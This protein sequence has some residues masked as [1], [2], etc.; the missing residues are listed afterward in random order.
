MDRR[1]FLTARRKPASRP[2][3][4]T[5]KPFRTESGLM[6][7][8][9]QWTLNEVTHLLKRTMFGASKADI[10]YFLSKTM[11][12]AVD[13]LLNPIA[14]LPSPPVNNYSGDTA[15]ASVAAGQTWINNPVMNNDDL[16]NARR[17]SFKKWWTGLMI[18]QDRSIREKLTLFWANHFGT[19]TSTIDVSHFVYKHN[20]LLRKNC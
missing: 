9:G 7:Y 14:P 15:D 19:Q 1:E 18:N 6:P 16:N 10:N 3:K 8:G 4:I 2:Q 12:Q 11:S 13:E 17:D 5:A 20:D